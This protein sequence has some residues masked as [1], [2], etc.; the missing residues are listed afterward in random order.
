MTLTTIASRCEASGRKGA[1]SRHC[2]SA[3]PPDHNGNSSFKLRGSL[4]DGL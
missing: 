1:L 3:G 2:V 4:M